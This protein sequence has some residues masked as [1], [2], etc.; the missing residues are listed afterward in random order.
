LGDAQ[1]GE[2]TRRSRSKGASKVPRRGSGQ[3]RVAPRPDGLTSAKAVEVALEAGGWKKSLKSMRASIDDAA[4]AVNLL[5]STLQELAPM[6]RSLSRLEEAVRDTGRIETAARPV[7]EA[8]TAGAPQSRPVA[9]EASRPEPTR[10]AEAAR[11]FEAAAVARK[12]ARRVVE[13][14]AIRPAAGSS[15]VHSYTLTVEDTKRRVDL[16]PLHRALRSVPGVRDMAL[17]G[18]TNGIATVTLDARSGLEPPALEAAIADTT[19]RE[20]KIWA[21]SADTFLVRVGT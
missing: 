20:C 17:L 8:P 13:G 5:R 9:G 21:R 11:S 14:R 10:A 7:G 4:G 12:P 18:Y 19:S 6:W 2:Y 1:L 15:A 16:V 3:K